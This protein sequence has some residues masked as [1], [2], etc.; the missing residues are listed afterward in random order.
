MPE[1]Y[2]NA[3]KAILTTEETSDQKTRDMVTAKSKKKIDNAIIVF[4]D[5]ILDSS[6]F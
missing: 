2:P 1:P 5:F 3:K 4:F 6:F